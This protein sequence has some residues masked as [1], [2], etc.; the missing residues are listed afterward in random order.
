[1]QWL[2]IVNPNHGD[3][4]HWRLVGKDKFK[5]FLA[6]EEEPTGDTLHQFRNG[7]NGRAYQETQICLG[8][9]VHASY[10]RPHAT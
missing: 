5:A 4:L 2:N 9:L 6:E 1:M 7:G 10:S 3:E 8:K